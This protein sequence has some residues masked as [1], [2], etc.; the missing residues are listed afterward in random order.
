[1]AQGLKGTVVSLIKQGIPLLMT[2]RACFPTILLSWQLQ[3]TSRAGWAHL[4]ETEVGREGSE[5]HGKGPMGETE[6]LRY[7]G[8][9]RK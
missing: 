6:G 1:M 5:H 8:T 4:G 7:L 2:S 3:G 9:L